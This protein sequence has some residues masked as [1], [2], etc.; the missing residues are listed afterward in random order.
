[1]STAKSAEN[2]AYLAAVILLASAGLAAAGERLQSKRVEVWRLI[3][4]QQMPNPDSADE[5]HNLI[6][7]LLGLCAVRL[8]T[9]WP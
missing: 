3:S 7:Q 5:I 4:A 9:H 1:M 8:S 6:W 2:V